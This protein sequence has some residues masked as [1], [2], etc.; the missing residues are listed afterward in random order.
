MKKILLAVTIL[1]S[2]LFTGCFNSVYFNV[3]KDVPP[4]DPTVT[5]T[6][7]QITR[8]TVGGKEYLAV[9]AEQGLLYKDASDKQYNSWKKYEALPPFEQHH[10]DYYGASDHVG[11][12]MLATH[13]D[14][15][16]LY[17]ITCEYKDSDKE[18]TAVPSK[19]HVYGKKIALAEDGI[20]WS[21]DGEWTSILED[22]SGIDYT[23]FYM[24]NTYSLSAFAIFSTNAVQTAHRKVY[25]RTGDPTPQ[26]KDYSK[27][28]AYYEISGTN[29]PAAISV[30]PAD[31]A[32]TEKNRANAAAYFNGNVEFYNS[33]A[34][35]TNETFESEAT[36]LYY[37]YNK[38]LYYKTADNPAYV[39][40]EF[41]LGQLAS[42]LCVCKDSIIIG[43][44]NLSAA[45]TSD[46]GGV[47]Q[48]SLDEN[49]I[50]GT[51]LTSFSSNIETQL[52]SAYYIL[53]MVNANPAETQAESG[54]YASIYFLGNG[55]STSARFS[56]IGLWSYYPGRGN[57][58]RE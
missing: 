17:L 55:S 38:Y 10:Y 37:G 15:D 34:V 50:I 44:G 2:V 9:V 53:S 54:L 49:G 13:A 14:V 41:A 8:Y 31:Y 5:G 1:I 25:I 35:T 16:T 36:V 4:L 45:D 7:R 29:G 23:P 19:M 11:Q 3:N 40:S 56:D 24:Y 28:V 21:A 58:N 39:K 33:V 48:T 52:Q 42:T 30:T 26:D 32:D 57:W 18:G 47:V 51:T 22:G 20:S 46:T 6:V 12:Q 43:R 27:D